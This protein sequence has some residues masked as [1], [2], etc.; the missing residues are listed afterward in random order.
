MINT[1][2]WFAN[3]KL[4]L[5]GEYLVMESAKALALPLNQ[6]QSLE[7][8]H[9]DEKILRWTALK[10][11]GKWFETEISIPD[12]KVVNSSDDNLSTKLEDI[13]KKATSLYGNTFNSGFN[14]T[15]KLDFDP[16]FGFGSS[17]TLIYNIARWLN[18][19]PY[20]LLKTT[21]GGSGYDIACAG[22]DKPIFY[23]RKNNE[24]IVSPVHFKPT[25]LENIYFVYL[26]KKQ[27]SADSISN[28]RKHGNY[29]ESDINIISEL[30]ERLVISKDLT[31]FEN[32][33]EKH[34]RIIS[35]ILGEKTIKERY[36]KDFPGTVKSLGAWGGDF[37]LM[38]N[39]ES[40]ES[41]IN[42]L[43]NIGYNTIF[44]YD[45]IVLR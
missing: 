8:E 2:N 6:G 20:L 23:L 11:G 16:E 27:R 25:F 38:T 34:E 1:G 18:L 32:I 31:E 43:N 42:R 22:N 45:E 28:F 24:I 10:P 13:L 41:F 7:V 12:I 33:L 3:G 19:D 17:S 5:T 36:F 26:N 30:S 39:H 29:S 37:V 40:H 9:N 21:F 35:G 14:I 4:L 44:K 15:T